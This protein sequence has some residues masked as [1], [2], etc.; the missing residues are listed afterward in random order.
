MLTLVNVTVG[1]HLFS[2]RTVSKMT[3]VSLVP[4]SL[5]IIVPFTDYS[6]ETLAKKVFLQVFLISMLYVQCWAAIAWFV[7]ELYRRWKT[8]K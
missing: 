7:G 3:L 1:Y 8:L 6:I 2:G 4:V 5:F